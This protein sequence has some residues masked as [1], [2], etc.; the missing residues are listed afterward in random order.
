M[1]SNSDQAAQDEAHE[2]LTREALAAVDEGH[3]VDHQTLL[4]WADSFNAERLSPP[5][6]SSTEERALGEGNVMKKRNVFAEIV[7]G[8]D[9]LKAQRE[10]KTTS[11]L[12]V[13]AAFRSLKPDAD[14]KEVAFF[15]QN[16]PLIDFGRKTALELIEA[17][18]T[19]DVVSYLESFRAGFVG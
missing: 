1:C 19:D 4:A 11:V 7:E 17:G 5:P 18:R 14:D 13:T 3:T 10:D 16:Y 6:H 9:A 2:R 12:R 8:F 15:L